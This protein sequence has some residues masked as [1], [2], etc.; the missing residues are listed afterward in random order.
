MPRQGDKAGSTAAIGFDYCN[1]LFA[2]EAELKEL[3]PEE[4]KE[5]RQELSRPVLEA[6][7]SW[8]EKVNPLQGSKLGEAV[9]Y[10]LNQK[11]ALG[12]FLKDGRIEISNNRAEN[13]IRHFVMGRKAWLFADTKKGATS[14]AIVYS[15]VETAKANNLNVYKYL[16]HIFTKMPA[17][18]FKNNPSLLEDLLPWSAKLPEDCR[19]STN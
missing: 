19:N 18:D 3:T 4:R 11:D 2:I 7:W 10:A 8:L 12:T 17:M 15:I 14:S 6:Y 13:A 1:K 16:T 9:K 5:K